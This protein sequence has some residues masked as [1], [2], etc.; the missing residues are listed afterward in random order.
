MTA[1]TTLQ[2]SMCRADIGDMNLPY[3]VDDSMLQSLFDDSTLAN[4]SLTKLRVYA[5]RQRRGIAVN[6]TG[7]TNQYG[8][9]S[10]NQK[11]E[12]IERLLTYWENFTG[13]S[14][15]QSATVVSTAPTRGDQDTLNTVF[16]WQADAFAARLLTNDPDAL[17]ETVD[18]TDDDDVDDD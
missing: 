2:K 16:A 17:A 3:D 6:A 5:L 18:D 4:G 1:L 14:A 12:Q 8:G 15:G 10:R 13:V 9:V 11:L 7:V